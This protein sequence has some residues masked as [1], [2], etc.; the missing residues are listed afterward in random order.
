MGVSIRFLGG[1]G[2]VTGSKYLVEHEG[3]RLL[4]DCGLF[5]GYKQYR[6]RNREPLPVVPGQ[7]GAVLFTHAH[8]D[9][10]GYFPL[11]ARDGFTGK[12]WCTPATRDLLHVM[13][14]DSG[15]LQE[16]EAAYA[17]RKGFSKHRP[18]LPLYTE[19]DARRSLKRLHTAG[20]HDSFEPLPGWTARFSGAGHILGAASVLL[21][22]GGRRILFS[23]D[24]GRPDDALMHPPEAPPEADVVLCESTYG[25]RLHPKE[26]LLGELGPALARAAARGGA[27]VVPVFAVGRAQAVLLAI[28]RLKA[29]GDLPR[30][31]PVYLDSPMAVQTTELYERH[32]GQHRLSA[33]ECREMER[34]AQM[35]TSVEQSKAIAQ[36]HGPK[37]ILAASGMATGGRV[38]HHLTHHLGDHRSMVVLAGY[39]APGTR[40][41]QLAA[42]IPSLRIF[43]QQWP[44]RAEVV[45]LTA[46]S[47]H[48]DADQLMAWLRQLP[49]APR[50]TFVTHGDMDAADGLRLRIEHEL[51]WPALVP[52]HGS[53]WPA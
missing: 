44:V 52:E 22:V 10:S 17:N 41:A 40:G 46:G 32:L 42:G 5:Q 30:G 35:V 18:A 49:R 19:D 28:A 4:V 14:P 16:E 31:L 2:T 53:T 29:R 12:A 21:T 34:T 51:G 23:G 37:V 11:L 45:Q 1:A 26:D 43:G 7:I 47:A 38:L 36:R 25:N 27:A 3:Q 15:H 8:I 33:A 13:L 50:R 48:A 9:H 39:Q 20:A 24:L 6:L